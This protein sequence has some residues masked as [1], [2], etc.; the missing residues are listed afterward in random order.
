VVS[1]PIGPTPG[2]VSSRLTT[3]RRSFACVPSVSSSA[4]HPLGGLAPDRVVMAD[5]VLE[6]SGNV[7]GGEQALPVRIGPQAASARTVPP[8]AP[9]EPLHGVYLGD[10]NPD[11]VPAAQQ[12]R[13]QLTIAGLGTWTTDW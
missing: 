11:E 9:Q 7:T 1:A 13:A 6:V 4:P 8:G 5:M 12:G 3:S 2:T 10:L